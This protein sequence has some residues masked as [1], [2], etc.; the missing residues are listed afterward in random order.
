MGRTPEILADHLILTSAGLARTGNLY[1]DDELLAS[2]GITD[3]DRYAAVP[4][5]RDF[6]N[7][8]VPRLLKRGP[9]EPHKRT[10]TMRMSSP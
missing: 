10:G 5:T 9:V 2:A 1:I 7:R 6:V 3:L 8:S 4:G